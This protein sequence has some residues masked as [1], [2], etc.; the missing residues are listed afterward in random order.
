LEKNDK[1]EIYINAIYFSIIT[2]VTVGYGDITPQ[3]IRE[4][5]Y[6]IIMTL[7]SS[8][9]FAYV[10]NTIGTIFTEIA[11]KENKLKTQ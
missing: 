10:V 9:N 6:L 1:K 4:K 8:I 3:N 7:F 2:M 11:N 5:I